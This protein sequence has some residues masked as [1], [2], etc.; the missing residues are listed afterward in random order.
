MPVVTTTRLDTIALVAIDNPPVNAASHAVRSVL[1]AA[2]AGALADP[3]VAAIV[4]ACEGRTFVAGADVRE[5]DQPPAPP[6]LPEI[7]DAIESAGKPVIAA[8][9]GTALG[10]GFEI[11]LGC[12]WRIATAG[13]KLGL[14]EV[15]L[16]LL[17]GA[18]GTQRLPRLVGIEA[19][20][21]MITGGKPVTAARAL[22]LGAL[23]EIA[24][25]DLREA[26]LALARRIVAEGRPPRRT[27]D[28]PLRAPDAG[29]LERAL[30]D[31]ARKARGRVAPVRAAEAVQLALRLPFAEA[32][33]REREMFLELRNSPQSRALRHAFF[34]EREVARI[35]DLPEGTPVR[36]I[37]RAAVIGAG[38][39]GG[40]IAMCFANAGLPVTLVEATADALDRGMATIRRNYAATVSRGGLTEDERDRRLARIAPTLA[41]EELREADIVIE[42]VF[43]D[44]GVK[45]A[46]FEKLDAIARPGAILATNTSYLDV[47]RI[48]SFTRR[49]ADVVGTHFFSPA[50]V[51]RLLENVRTAETAPD[52]Q[53]TVM[54]LGKALGK[55]AVMVGGK[56]GF[57]GNRMLAQR[58]REAFFLLEEGALPHQVDRVLT[59][60]GF[61]MG[62]FAVS[63][64]AGLDIGWRVRKANAPLR[65]PGVRDCN[66]I[67]QVCALGR[68]GQKTGA[69]WYRYEGGSRAPLADPVVEEL[70]V[71]HSRAIGMERRAIG[72]D[73]ILGRLLYAMVNEGARILAEG[74]ALRAVDIDMVWLHGY[75]FPAHRGGPMFHA[76][77]TGLAQVL[78]A[79]R[80]FR[81]R[82]GPDFWTPA[83]LIEKLGT[84]GGQFRTWEK[85]K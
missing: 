83:P 14:P 33:A 16:G 25:G 50:N 28:L 49:P 39:M 13:A 20:L 55:V 19:A 68:F 72:D 59:D 61:P 21:D 10:G 43:E 44:I 42:A 36:E 58:T 6:L 79:I 65:K 22:A 64:L 54:K 1:R 5:F 18:G 37:R 78:A 3:A 85:T 69:G 67:D 56:D 23:D 52:V 71:A 75:G 32:A 60:F 48:A 7:I 57:V 80:G 74:V 17:P 15:T 62:H 11:A 51:M 76:D 70:I 66:L 84:S 41:Y 73:E 12:H 35:P 82:F 9:H 26:A 30:G 29:T 46:T 31:I 40:G 47:A 2:I 8:I 38:T 63:D 81:D 77:E 4:L 53:A 27:R 34:G 45:Q 24:G